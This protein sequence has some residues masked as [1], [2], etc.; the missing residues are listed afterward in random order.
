MEKI[1]ADINSLKIHSFQI[2]NLLLTYTFSNAP[3]SI[4]S[5]WKIQEQMKD[6]IKV[7]C[8]TLLFVSNEQDWETIVADQQENNRGYEELIVEMLEFLVKCISEPK[9]YQEIFVSSR[10]LLMV[11]LGFTFLRTTRQERERMVSDSDDFVHLALD[12][13]DK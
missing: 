8:S 11:N 13:C 2:I 4:T 6:I 10:R 1:D 3:L 7:V 5:T 12:T 9:H